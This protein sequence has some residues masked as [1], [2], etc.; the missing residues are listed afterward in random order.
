MGARTNS[1]RRIYSDGK[2]GTAAASGKQHHQQYQRLVTG[3]LDDLLLMTKRYTE[4]TSFSISSCSIPAVLTLVSFLSF[5]SQSLFL[6]FEPLNLVE[7]VIF[8][9][10]ITFLLI[11]YVR[12]IITDPGRIK[13]TNTGDDNSKVE[14]DRESASKSRQR[15][16]IA[17]EQKKPPRAHHCR[18]CKRSESSKLM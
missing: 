5:S 15:W 4:M 13:L 2:T 10:G 12:A 8:N 7:A 18:K 9:V 3:L 11:C 17:C 14:M 1:A 6:K 16:C